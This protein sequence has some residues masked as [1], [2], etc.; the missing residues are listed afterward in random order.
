MFKE[1]A[2]HYQ[3]SFHPFCPSA[4]IGD[5][6]KWESL[7]ASLRQNLIDD[8]VSHRNVSYPV[9]QATDYLGFSRTGNR[10]LYEDKLFARRTILNALVLGECVEFQGNF[11]DDIINGIYVICEESAWQLPAHNS[12]IRDTVQL[13]LPDVTRPILDLFAAETG[14]VLAAVN[15]MMRDSLST[16]SPMIS[17]MIAKKLEE[18]MF[19]PYLNEHFWWMGDG[20]TP[21]NNWTVWCT[22]NVLIAAFLSDMEETRK[23]QIVQKACESI[24]YFLAE[25]GEDGCCDEGAQYYRHAGL[26]LFNCMEILNA[27][28]GGHF[29]PLYQQEKVRN[30]ASYILNVHVA[31]ETYI[32]FSDC[33]PMA[34]RCNAREFLFGK[35]TENP[36][37][38]KM[39]AYDYRHSRLPL[40]PQEHNLYYRL[41]TVFHHTEMMEYP[42][43]TP[44]IHR[45]LFYPSVGLFMARDSRYCL[46]VKAGDND[47]SHNHNDT[48]SFTLYKDGIPLFIDIGVETYQKKTFSPQRYEIWT[49]QSRFHNLPTF[50]EASALPENTDISLH[51]Q[52]MQKDGAAYSAKNVSHYFSDSSSGISFDIADAYGDSR[53]QSYERKVTLRK[54]EGISV[55]DHAVCHGLTPVLSLITYETPVWDAPH[56][57]LSM[58]SA[59]VC[60]INGAARI[61]AE[62]V[63]ITDPRLQTAWKHDIW[64]VQVVFAGDSLELDIQ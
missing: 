27:V 55:T 22:Q 8:A 5:R 16:V 7:D 31:E 13:P 3:Q 39:A 30:I 26:C 21:M 6:G 56:R 47:D 20:I 64:R 11:L 44:V 59:A 10:V 45:E 42:V 46:G 17:P 60:R 25:Y 54:G 4:P 19:T 43:D 15:Y 14:A 53:I 48:G 41:Q 35:R 24:D 62:P 28:T 32:N 29:A 33:S 49:M 18:R 36:E 51:T 57:C 23:K 50:F 37:L 1:L 34:G 61:M 38:C 12:Y 63:P 52:I 9:L 40:L 2:R 58:G